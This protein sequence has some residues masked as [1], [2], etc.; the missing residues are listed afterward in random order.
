MGVKG[1]FNL[2]DHIID[3]VIQTDKV[4]KFQKEIFFNTASQIIFLSFLRKFT[5][6][7]NNKDA[8]VHTCVGDEKDSRDPDIET[9]SVESSS[10]KITDVGSLELC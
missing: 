5:I 1:I 4:L 9:A 3:Y 2:A 6:N 7:Q 10:F 8:R